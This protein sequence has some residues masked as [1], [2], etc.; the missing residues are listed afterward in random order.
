MYVDH[1]PNG[2]IA[3]IA[4][5]LAT[6]TAQLN[7]SSP[8]NLENKY[9][10]KILYDRIHQVS[11]SGR[12]NAHGNFYKKVNF[13]IRYGGNSGGI[14]D[15]RTNSVGILMISNEATNDPVV[16]SFFRMRYIDN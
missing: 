9:R 8:L 15:L 3:T 1:Q 12:Q 16:T 11:I 14:A 10:F 7:I 5:I 13:P 2:A 6:T 4:D